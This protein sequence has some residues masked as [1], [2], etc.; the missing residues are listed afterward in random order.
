MKKKITWMTM[1][2]ICL[3]ASLLFCGCGEKGGSGPAGAVESFLNAAKKMDLDEMAKYETDGKWTGQ[4][5]EMLTIKA[6]EKVM[7]K[8]ASKMTYS[9]NE[10]EVKEEGDQATVQAEISYIDGTS[11]FTEIL[12]EYFTQALSMAAGDDQEMDED[13][14]LQLLEDIV[15]DKLDSMEE[16]VTKET[17]TFTCKKDG[18][19]KVDNPGEDFTNVM[20]ANLLKASSQIGG[21]LFDSGEE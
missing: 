20:T 3:V 2:L 8:T 11:F 10:K 5:K 21:D 7:K 17:V 12:T 9:I 15:D 19:W 18:G 16:T 14:V 1:L 6:W 13:Q 4:M